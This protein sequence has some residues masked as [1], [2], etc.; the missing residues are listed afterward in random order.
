MNNQIQY[1]T[2]KEVAEITG[3]ALSTLRNER[4]LGKGIPYLK[5]GKS[6]RYNYEDVIEFMES[7]RIETI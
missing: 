1:I 7:R 2:E 5:I 4:F 6:V 3:R